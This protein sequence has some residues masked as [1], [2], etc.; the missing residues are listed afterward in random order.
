MCVAIENLL[1]LFINVNIYKYYNATSCSSRHGGNIAG[2][3]GNGNIILEMTQS[4]LAIDL[5]VEGK[6]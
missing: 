4:M 3:I 6:L 5:S 2:R 1:K